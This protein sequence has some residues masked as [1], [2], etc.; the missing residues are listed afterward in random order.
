LV[1]ALAVAEVVPFAYVVADESL[2]VTFSPADVDNVKPE[3]DRLL[4]VPTVPPAAGPDRAL[5]PPP[6]APPPGPGCPDAVDEDV[7]VDGVVVAEDDA[8]QPAESPITA[9]ITAAATT[10]PLLLLDGAG[11]VSWGPVGPQSFMVALLFT[12]ATTQRVPTVH[13]RSL[14][15]ACAAA[16]TRRAS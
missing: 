9:H 7:A 12:Q 4:T 13:V 1:T 5:D 3:V 14:W 15:A 2:T 16:V 10:R 11:R 6:P 8:P